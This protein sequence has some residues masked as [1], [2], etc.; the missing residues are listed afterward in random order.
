M[1]YTNRLLLLYWLTSRAT[2]PGPNH[3]TQFGSRALSRKNAHKCSIN[4]LPVYKSAAVYR[5]QHA[6]GGTDI[7]Y[8]ATGLATSST[9]QSLNRMLTLS[10]R[11][12]LAL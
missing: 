3:L 11:S 7:H 6:S 8:T 10:L 4:T 9:N 12:A 2:R 1:R 5:H